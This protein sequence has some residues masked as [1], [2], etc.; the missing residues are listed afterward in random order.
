MR[1][2]EIKTARQLGGTRAD[3]KTI[4]R[5]ESYQKLLYTQEKFNRSALPAPAVVLRKLDITPPGSANS[6]GY[7]LLRCPFHKNGQEQHS[8]LNLHAVSGHYRCHACGAV[9]GDVLAFY[10]ALTG[11][12]FADAS[13]DLGAWR[14][15]V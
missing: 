5:L 13:R 4:L 3:K 9:G 7:F 2:P 1:P 10:M 11:K 15:G 6:A 8:S 14:G 12:G